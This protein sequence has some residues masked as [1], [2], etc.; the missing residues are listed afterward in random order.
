MA[1]SDSQI[2]TVR[3]MAG[4]SSFA[5]VKTVV[6][7]LDEV[8]LTP[9]EAYLERWEA[10]EQKHLRVGGGKDGIDL[11]YD[12]ER[13]FLRVNTR[14]MLGLPAYSDAELAADPNVFQLVELCLY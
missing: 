12:R 5:A 2:E 7:G 6:E 11:D 4:E 8:Q 1:L 3:R 14:V 13:S 9:L 10:L